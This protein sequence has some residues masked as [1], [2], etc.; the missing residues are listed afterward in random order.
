MSS[1]QG[2]AEL[3]YSTRILAATPPGRWSPGAEEIAHKTG[4]PATLVR[5]ALASSILA[6]NKDPQRAAAA[7]RTVPRAHSAAATEAVAGSVS[8]TDLRAEETRRSQAALGP[9]W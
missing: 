4:L 8:V 3:L 2:G 6:W 1:G 9:L 5:T 7:W